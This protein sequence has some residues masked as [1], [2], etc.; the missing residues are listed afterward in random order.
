MKFLISLLL[1]VLSSSSFASTLL[2]DCKSL[3]VAGV[4]KF[5]ARGFVNI[6][7]QYCR[8]IHFAKN[9]KGSS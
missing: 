6:N 7:R 9:S 8:W 3:E 4:H 1:L 2:F 5:D